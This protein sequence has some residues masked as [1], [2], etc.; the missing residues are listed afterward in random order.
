[1]NVRLIVRLLGAILLLEALT[2][3]PAL[4]IAMVYGEGD[5]MAL[6]V[7]MVITAAVAL[8]GMPSESSGT[9]A[10]PTLALLALSGTMTPSG[11]P[12]PKRSGCLSQRFTSL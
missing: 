8:P 1:M 3:L 9:S 12:A 5:A 4:V 6:L 11:V 10:P 2:M 7:S